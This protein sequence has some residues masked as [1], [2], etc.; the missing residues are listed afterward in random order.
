[1]CFDADNRNK[2][3]EILGISRVNLI[4]KIKKCHLS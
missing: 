3:A 1:M 2:A 4:A